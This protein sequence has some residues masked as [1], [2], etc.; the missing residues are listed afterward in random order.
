MSE[1]QQQPRPDDT[2]LGQSSSAPI[3]S[4]I[5]GGLA[6]V[7]QRLASGTSEQ[8][9]DALLDAFR[10]GRDGLDVAIEALKNPAKDVKFA[11]YLLLQDRPELEVKQ[12]LQTY[13]PYKFFQCLQ[14]LQ[15]HTLGVRCAVISP[16]GK[17]LISNSYEKDIKVWD[18]QTGQVVRTLVGHTSEVRSLAISPDGKHLASTSTDQTLNVWDWQTGQ[19]VRTLR[20]YVSKYFSKARQEYVPNLF[21]VAIATDGTTLA[22]GSYQFIETWNL[23]TGESLYVFDA[24]C[25]LTCAIAINSNDMTLVSGGSDSKFIK[26]WNLNTGT[27]ARTLTGHSSN[28]IA[29]AISPDGKTLISSSEDMTVKVWDLSTGQVNYTLNLDNTGKTVSSLAISPDGR[30]FVGGGCTFVGKP[31]WD[32]TYG[33]RVWD[34]KTGQRLH[35][36]TGHSSHVSSVAFAPDGCTLVSGSGDGTIKMWG[37]PD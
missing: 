17:Y 11:A 6:G 15:G 7:K 32:S 29:L 19:V 21:S 1:N 26:V 35:T 28:I 16:D 22:S 14:T 5:L 31:L 25:G 20:G 2:V 12:A 9:I 8:K 27:L 34:L 33:I 18:L 10:Y 30:T 23:K 4:V 3:G 37:I 13:H 24:Y 36:L